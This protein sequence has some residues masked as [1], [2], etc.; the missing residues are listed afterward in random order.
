ME[1]ELLARPLPGRPLSVVVLAAGQSKRMGQHKL[2][3]PFG[4]E[5][6]LTQTLKNILQARIG[7]IYLVVGHHKED[8]YK[9]L[10]QKGLLEEVCI[11][12]NPSYETG[13][14]SSVKSGIQ[15]LPEKN[16]AMFALGDQPLV[17]PALYQELAQAY[18]GGR[19]PLVVPVDA[20]GKRG[21]PT[22]FAPELF[23]EIAQLQGDTGP[24]SLLDK[25]QDRILH[26]LSQEAGIHFDIDTKE[27]Y[28]K[29]LREA[30]LI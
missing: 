28:E 26:V 19:H 11:I 24:R 7:T 25:Y 6:I 20:Q 3:L 9:V 13:Q 8:I 4:E 15:A 2:L 5:T 17:T 21:N 12:V 18:R 23:P 14:S 22:V 10:E 1:K 16:G 27:A 30:G 29:S